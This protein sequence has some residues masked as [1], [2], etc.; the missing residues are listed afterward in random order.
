MTRSKEV[1]QRGVSQKGTS[2]KKG[3]KRFAPALLGWYDLHGR[4]LPW[5]RR[6]PELAPPYYVFLSELM[7]QQTVVATVIPYFEV[8]IRRWPDLT[9]LAGA[10][11]EDITSA[12][13]GLGYYARARNLHKAAALLVADHG[14]VFPRSVDGLM[15]L[16]GIGPYTASAISA[17]AFDQPAIVIDG[18]IERVLSRYFGLDTPLPA[19]KK[20]IAKHYPALVPK[21]RRSDFP[22]ALMDLAGMVCLPKKALC[23]RCPLAF[24]CVGAGWDD[25]TILPVKPAKK[26]RPT[27]KGQAYV[28]VDKDGAV[29]VLRRPARGLLGGM[30]GF[31]SNGWDKAGAGFDWL[32]DEFALD[33]VDTQIVRHIFTHFAAEISVTRIIW[34]PDTPLPAPLFWAQAGDI[35]LPT[36]MAKILKSALKP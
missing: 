3:A 27:R 7:L 10:P 17:F 13:A 24:G 15:K 5:R 30:L 32:S 23:D 21:T 28:L 19:L 20:E 14:A 35:A 2:Q 9:A 4:D 36:L 11:I 22:Q 33:T 34:P 26:P 16:P 12:W 1:S 25:P 8:F 29:A 18:N 6:W 31:P